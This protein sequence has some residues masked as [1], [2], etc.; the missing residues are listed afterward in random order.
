MIQGYYPHGLRT[1]AMKVSIFERWL[2]ARRLKKRRKR[3]QDLE[4]L[5]WY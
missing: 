4:D 2:M 1:P 5:R 3:Q